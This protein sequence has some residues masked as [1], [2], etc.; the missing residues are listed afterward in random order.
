MPCSQRLGADSITPSGWNGLTVDDNADATGLEEFRHRPV[1]FQNSL[2]IEYAQ[3]FHFYPVF[4]N[5][6]EKPER[7]Q[8]ADASLLTRYT[9]RLAA[10]AGATRRTCN[11]GH[12]KRHHQNG[13]ERSTNYAHH[14]TCN[15]NH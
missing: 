10:L 15:V 11:C 2:E 14:F 9:V 13:S 5:G 12:G 7:L 8:L 3:A 6:G 4:G 1:Q